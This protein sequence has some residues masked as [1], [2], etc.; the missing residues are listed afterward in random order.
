MTE[1]SHRDQ[2]DEILELLE[3]IDQ[4]IAP[5]TLRT[6]YTDHTNYH[7][8]MDNLIEPMIEDGELV[9]IPNST[10]GKLIQKRSKVRELLEA[11]LDKNE[12]P[13]QS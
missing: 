2:K 10:K 5:S 6:Q 8:Y 13:D 4:F 9:E 12:A 3:D 1:D 11:V 7:K